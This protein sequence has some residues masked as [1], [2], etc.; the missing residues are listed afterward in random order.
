MRQVWREDRRPGIDAI[1]WLTKKS[2]RETKRKVLID[3]K[4]CIKVL[5]TFINLTRNNKVC[6][7]VSYIG[8]NSDCN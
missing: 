3:I 8:F 5:K 2:L 4:K 7:V 1:G 6:Y